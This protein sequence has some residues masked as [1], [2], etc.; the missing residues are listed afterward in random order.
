MSTQSQLSE[1]HLQNVIL[2]AIDRFKQEVKDTGTTDWEAFDTLIV[3]IRAYTA[4]FSNDEYLSTIKTE[5]YNFINYCESQHVLDS[6]QCSV[7]VS[8]IREQFSAVMKEHEEI[9]QLAF[10]IKSLYT[11]DNMFTA[12]STIDRYSFD[13]I[14]MLLDLP[15]RLVKFIN[16]QSF[17]I[18][19]FEATCKAHAM[20]VTT[21]STINGTR[22]TEYLRIL[23]IIGLLEQDIN[24]SWVEDVAENTDE[25][26][27]H[28]A[29]LMGID[30]S[31]EYSNVF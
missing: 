26:R 31:G 21:P 27:K 29:E 25:F 7:Y 18:D 11:T 28:L 16:S 22:Y 19:L 23:Y 20:Y 14:A 2:L 12:N 9:T 10:L 17:R 13:T 8:R 4:S 24:D 15:Q 3:N 5:M 1:F 30:L 6:A